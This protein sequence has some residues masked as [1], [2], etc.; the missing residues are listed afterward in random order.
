MGDSRDRLWSIC[1]LIPGA[2]QAQ[3]SS[4]CRTQSDPARVSD[5]PAATR[6]NETGARHLH[7]PDAS[8]FPRLSVR[9]LRHWE[10]RV[11][12]GQLH[13]RHY[14]D[15]HPRQRPPVPRDLVCQLMQRCNRAGQLLPMEEFKPGDAVEVIKG[16]FADFIATVQSIDADRRVW[17]LMEIMGGGRTGSRSAR[18]R[19]EQ[20]D[21]R[22][23]ATKQRTIRGRRENAATVVKA[24]ESF[25]PVLRERPQSPAPA[26][27][28]AACAISQAQHF[29]VVVARR[30]RYWSSGAAT[31]ACR[32]ALRPD[33]RKSHSRN[34]RRRHFLL[35]A[36]AQ[37]FTAQ[38]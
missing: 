7:H 24:G 17:V 8:A 26:P 30:L 15:R 36:R 19:C 33:R 31:S 5:I 22:Q 18:S 13:L 20:S 1:H 27:W 4:H 9:G 28:Q 25:A 32:H 38:I 14:P 12:Q 29:S 16:P 34:P 10:R 6:G 23:N 21:R 35:L 3:Q 11:A 37:V 2:V